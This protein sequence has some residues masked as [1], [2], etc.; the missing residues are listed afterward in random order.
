MLKKENKYIYNSTIRSVFNKIY[1]KY[2]DNIFLASESCS[3]NNISREYSFKDVKKHIKNNIFFFKKCE[4]STGDRIA[5]VVG[6]N[7]EYFI[8]KLS[9]NYF[10]LSCIPINNELSAKEIYF[11][12]KNADPK[13]IIFSLNNKKLIKNAITVKEKLTVGFIS[14]NSNNRNK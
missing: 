6:N 13:Y 1:K 14:F 9:L 11:I 7:P 5:V 4:L 2:P 3:F 10:G 8:L 12:I